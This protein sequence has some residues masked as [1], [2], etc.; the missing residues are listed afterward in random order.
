MS[1]SELCAGSTYIL[2]SRE[3]HCVRLD[4]TTEYY[5]TVDRG[6]SSVKSAN[7]KACV[8]DDHKIFF[9]F[10]SSFPGL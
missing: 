3:H 9:T 1:S 2:L 5:H 7:C 6:R 8:S 4:G 10:S